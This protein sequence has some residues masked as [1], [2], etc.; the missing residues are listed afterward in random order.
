MSN[1]IFGLMARALKDR[2]LRQSNQEKMRYDGIFPFPDVLGALNDN[3]IIEKRPDKLEFVRNPKGFLWAPDPPERIYN[4]KYDV[5]LE[6]RDGQITRAVTR[7]DDESLRREGDEWAHY[8]PIDT[9]I[10]RIKENADKDFE[11]QEMQHDGLY[12]T[13]KIIDLGGEVLSASKA[14][15]PSAASYEKDRVIRLRSNGAR[16]IT[17]MFDDPK[18]WVHRSVSAALDGQGRLRPTI[19]KSDAL[20]M[21][22]DYTRMEAIER[23]MLPYLM[24]HRGQPIKILELGSEEAVP[25]QHLSAFIKS[26][27][28]NKVQFIGYSD[29]HIP[30]WIEFKF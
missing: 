17:P 4:E 12:Y 20:K 25:L 18:D 30:N 14:P 22:T 3:G 27:G 23:S 8:F 15:E 26:Q 7:I 10:K 28:F 13:V 11:L 2:N 9:A 19:L 21:F 29:L 5:Y 16:I 24:R 6:V 1:I